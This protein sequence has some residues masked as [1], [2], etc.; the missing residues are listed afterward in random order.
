M[1]VAGHR[2]AGNRRFLNFEVQGATGQL[3]L[4]GIDLHGVIAGFPVGGFEGFQ[5]H[6]DIAEFL[7]FADEWTGQQSDFFFAEQRVAGDPNVL[8]VKDIVSRQCKVGTE[9][10]REG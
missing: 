5:R 3:L 10:E 4:G 7:V 9:Q 2:D 1:F 8:Q 6:L